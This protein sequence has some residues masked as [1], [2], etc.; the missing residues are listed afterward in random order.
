MERSPEYY[1][2]K[3]AGC[4]D[5]LTELF[6]VIFERTQLPE[7]VYRRCDGLLNLYR[8]TELGIFEKSCQLAIDHNRPTYSFVRHVIE[9]NTWRL[10]G[11]EEE[12]PQKSLPE[13]PNIRG[14]EYYT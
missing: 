11:T 6:R 9:K 10:D 5:V 14:K 3:A 1:L 13:H 12:N 4:S 8:K 2:E 7:T